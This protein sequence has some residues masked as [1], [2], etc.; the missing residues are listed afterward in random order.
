MDVNE[1]KNLVLI[2]Q[3]GFRKSA[4]GK[5]WLILRL[6]RGRGVHE[7]LYVIVKGRVEKDDYKTLMDGGWIGDY[8]INASKSKIGEYYLYVTNVTYKKDDDK[9]RE[10]IN[11]LIGEKI[12]VAGKYA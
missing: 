1:I 10:V 4:E 3:K 8:F 5:N 12:R 11:K 6:D 7:E 9:A 2:R